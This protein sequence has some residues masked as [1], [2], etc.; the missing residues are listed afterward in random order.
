MRQKDKET[1]MTTKLAVLKSCAL[2][3]AG[4]LLGAGQDK[5]EQTKTPLHAASQFKRMIDKGALGSEAKKPAK[6]FSG[7]I[8][9]PAGQPDPGMVGS[10]QRP[11]VRIPVAGGKQA[12]T[13]LT[14][15]SI[16]EADFAYFDSKAA[17]K[18][19]AESIITGPRAGS[20]DSR[21][22]LIGP[23]DGSIVAP[24]QTFTW[25]PG[26]GVQAYYLWVGSCHDC[27]DIL[28]ED[29]G[30]NLSR[31]IALPND[32][33]IIY[34]TLFSL[35]D[36]NWYWVDYEFVASR[37]VVAAALTMPGNG[38][39]V[40]DPQTFDW[41]LGAG[42][43]D[44]WLSIGT[45]FQCGDI[46]DEDEGLGTRRT[47]GLPSNGITLFVSLSSHGSD[48]NWYW[49]NYQFRASNSAWV[50]VQVNITNNYLYPMNIFVNGT[51]VGSVDPS[52]TQYLDTRVNPLEVSFQLLQPILGGKT[53]GDPVNGYW[54]AINNPSGTYNFT[55]GYRLGATYY[56]LPQITN[57]TGADLE[58]EVNGGYGS[59]N[60]CDCY[61][62]SYTQ[63]VRAGYYQLFSNSNVR[64]FLEGNNYTGPYLY[65][66]T[67][68]NGNISPSGPLYSLVQN[69][70][71]LV[72][73]AA[74]FV[75]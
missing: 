13:V 22:Y 37:P 70:S 65:F 19:Q 20:S 53:L 48:G 18:M 12:E 51:L 21:A 61:A 26:V 40:G 72:S 6:T 41:T 33:R 11:E 71:G 63:N 56:F 64:L 36:N 49:I 9:K 42:I 17:Q 30:L 57:E 67:E 62:P 16:H 69:P 3:L 59:E 15:E 32:G 23:T 2:I 43:R 14:M 5:P 45:C 35:I 1:T 66:G 60:R 58:I 31:T 25:S 7:K 68:P 73:L 4:A 74:T 55:A 38:W 44:I 28:D 50:P 24:T 54:S 34:F 46:L 47:V 75:P 39:T 29:E 8:Q 27:T 10:P 52:S